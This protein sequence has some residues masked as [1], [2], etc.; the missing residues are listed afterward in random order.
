MFYPVQSSVGVLHLGIM[1]SYR[2]YV[3]WHNMILII[4]HMPLISVD[5]AG[6]TNLP[7]W[8]NVRDFAD[9]ILR[10]I[11][12]NKKLCILIKNSVKIVPEGP[13][14]NKPVFV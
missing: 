14:D 13:I 12:V 2:A 4:S 9:D 3:E 7:P 6:F 1:S 5:L 11:F 8:Q 10:C